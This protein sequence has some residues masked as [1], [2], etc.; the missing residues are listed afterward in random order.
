M[1]KSW[2]GDIPNT[3]IRDY[4]RKRLYQAEDS[5]M[6]WGDTEIL[7]RERIEDL[8]SEISIWAK[9]N[10][11]QIVE[12]GHH[13][14]YAT[15]KVISLP[16]PISK[17]LPYITHEMSHVINYNGTEADHHG[18]NFAGTYLMVVRKFI[19]EQAYK[20]L[21]GAFRSNKVS[22]IFWDTKS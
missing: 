21:M 10:P 22:F 4:Q 14:V 9:I 3:H 20:D 11:P 6:Y 1:Q 7:T 16:Y 5:C 8:V 15:K 18:K 17:T 12:D 2:V 13:L 19:G